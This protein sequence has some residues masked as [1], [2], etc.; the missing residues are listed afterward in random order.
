M[1][2]RSRDKNP[3][4][5][6]CSTKSTYKK[7]AL[8]FH[9]NFNRGCETESTVKYQELEKLCAPNKALWQDE[10]RRKDPENARAEAERE[11][12]E[13]EE[14]KKE[15]EE[16]AARHFA[17]QAQGRP[18]PP[19][20]PP[21]APPQS[22]RPPSP[23]RARPQSSRAP[24]QQTSAAA[25]EARKRAAAAEKEKEESKKRAAAA[26]KEKEEARKRAAAA[27]KEKEESK[28]RAAAAEKEKEIARKRAAAAEREETVR[29]Q[30]EAE[31]NNAEIERQREEAERMR[32]REEAE[33]MRQITIV[34]DE[35]IAIFLRN[36]ETIQTLYKKLNQDILTRTGR[37]WE[38]SDNVKSK[39]HSAE[40]YITRLREDKIQ[41]HLLL[42]ELLS[43]L[44]TDDINK[45]HEMFQNNN[46]PSP[47]DLN[48]KNRLDKKIIEMKESTIIKWKNTITVSMLEN[49]INEAKQVFM[50]EY[51]LII[52]YINM[53]H[54]PSGSH[55]G[56][57]S[58]HN[59]KKLNISKK[60]RKINIRG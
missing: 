34:N 41:Y 39:S 33:R 42:H 25:E 27:E 58:K 35:Q 7:A 23:P 47:Y 14:R 17:A 40:H 5:T 53:T 20:S 50:A 45:I 21:R 11:R 31:I 9:P 38:L 2:C 48:Y 28:K 8:I 16:G 59:K 55:G 12:R 36:I 60:N 1:S 24:P 43:I 46:I 30:R 6:N 44:R 15:Q 29:K 4:A 49:I 54:T 51:F 57:K 32:Q 19:P 3:S 22:S 52:E 37:G 10:E 26:E 56:N 18:P 13:H